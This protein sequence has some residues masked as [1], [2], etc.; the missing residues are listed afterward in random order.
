MNVATVQSSVS[1]SDT[2]ERSESSV[3]TARAPAGSGHEYASKVAP[4]LRRGVGSG[5]LTA[6]VGGAGLL[7]GL[8]A[9][10]RG[11][12]KRGVARVVFGAAFLTVAVAQ[13]R[14]RGP[15]KESDVEETDV[16]GSGP[17][18]EAIADEAGDVGDDDH[19]AGEAASAVADTSPD[20]EDAGSELDSES[21]TELGSDA[22]STSVD[23]REVAD[24]GVDS[25]DLSETTGRDSAET[26]TTETET[27]ETETEDAGDATGS[28]EVDRL[29]EAAFDGQ[30]HEVPAPQRAFNRG[31]LAHSTEAFWGV[32][33]RDDA[34]LVSQDY[35]ALS[36]PDGVTYVA[37]S[38]IGDDV[39][40]LPIPDTVLDHWGEVLGGTAVAGGDGILFA[41]TDDLAADGLLWVLPAAW[42]DDV[43]GEPEPSGQTE[44]AAPRR[45]TPRTPPDSSSAASC[46][47]VS[48]GTGH[49]RTTVSATLPRR[50]R[51]S[52]CRPRVPRATTSA[53]TS[54]ACF[55][56]S[57]AGRPSRTLVVA[58]SVRSAMAE[59]T[60]S[61][62]S[63]S[64]SW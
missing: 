37:S 29:G 47:T 6:I 15:E 7:G 16:V 5:A 10:L 1:Q 32:R 49:V 46:L 24:T 21:R 36:G 28:E 40:E 61:P 59:S 58:P 23:Q 25:Q 53:S 64:A 34:V 44:S 26:E 52:P 31:L 14:S 13:R 54:R 50:N 8:R 3:G 42:A 11:E 48:T 20:V 12:R 18:V 51:F 9:L 22:A 63:A 43:F 38:Q 56:I 4:S 2:G 60:R 57:E 62:R 19:A 35:D 45:E 41:T 30:S 27:T 39:R 33:D 17:D 55:D